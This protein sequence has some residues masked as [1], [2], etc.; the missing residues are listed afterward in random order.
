MGFVVDY[1]H[2]A[3]QKSLSRIKELVS[4]EMFSTKLDNK[5][6]LTH[7]NTQKVQSTSKLKFY[8]LGPRQRLKQ[9]LWS[10]CLGMPSK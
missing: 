4:Q 6:S 7:L 10:V 3:E 9:S 1:L 5:Q 2:N 8:I